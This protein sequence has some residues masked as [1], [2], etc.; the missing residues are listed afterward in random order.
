MRRNL[1]FVLILFLCLGLTACTP[2]AEGTPSPTPTATPKPTP[3]STPAPTP[4]PT[5]ELTP[6]PRPTPVPGPLGA[7]KNV[8]PEAEEVLEVAREYVQRQCEAAHFP[9]YYARYEHD[10]P[11]PVY[12]NWRIN[13]LERFYKGD[14]LV[15]GYSVEFYSI[16]YELH[17]ET[18]E[19]GYLFLA[20][21]HMH[22]NDDGWCSYKPCAYLVFL[23]GGESGTPQYYGAFEDNWLDP[24]D[25]CFEMDARAAAMEVIR[26]SALGYPIP[27]T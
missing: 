26:N 9:E 22:V 17:T 15:P 27:A 19:L 24:E 1:S 12:D 11:C 14:D 20:G 5:L 6:A 23:R 7:V 2:A 10:T 3:T 4:E 25:D 8:S 21:G 13:S 16:A 18:P